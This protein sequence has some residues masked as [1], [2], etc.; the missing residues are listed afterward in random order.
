M[1]GLGAAVLFGLSTPL[2]K[3]L[4]PFSGTFMFAGLLYLGAGIGLAAA[5]PADA[6]TQICEQYGSATIQGGRYVVQNNRWGTSSTQC[7]TPTSTGFTVD[8]ADGSVATNGAPKSYP[9]VFFGCHYGNCSET[10][11][12]L[13][14]SGLQASDQRFRQI[15]TSV[16]MTYPSSGTY[17]AAYDIWFNKSQPSATTG[18]NDGAELMVW[19]N[20][21]GSIQ[22]IGSRVG[23]ARSP[24]GGM[25]FRRCASLVR[26]ANRGIP[27]RGCGS[28]TRRAPGG[29]QFSITRAARKSPA[30]FS[31]A[32]C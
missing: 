22:P 26:P 17:D 3:L 8:R 10:G 15:S 23:T 27:I 6:A 1:S 20:H 12:L 21:T 31:A 24:C 25:I 32:T 5:P 16:S 29:C 19:L 14:A 30:V 11:G 18:Q 7:I 4:L 9:S 2:A 28:F 13:G